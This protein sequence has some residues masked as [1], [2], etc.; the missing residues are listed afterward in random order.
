MK[1]KDLVYLSVFNLKEFVSATG[2]TNIAG[3]I[4]PEDILNCGK[5]ARYL[6]SYQYIKIHSMSVEWITSGPTF[7]MSMYDS[8]SSGHGTE[9]TQEPYFERQSTLRLHRSDRNGRK[10]II[11]RTQKLGMKSQYQDYID[12]STIKNHVEHTTNQ[13]SLKWIAPNQL[14]DGQK[15]SCMH[16]FVVSVYGIK[17]NLAADTNAQVAVITE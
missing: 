14:N 13:C 1:P 6:T 17:D 7:L 3:I 5:L 4:K 10:G 12:T 16:K 15:I 11:S 9:H 2:S 8:D